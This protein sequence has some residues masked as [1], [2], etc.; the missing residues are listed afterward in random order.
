MQGVD[1]VLW[2]QTLQNQMQSM[3]AAAVAQQAANDQIRIRLETQI[4]I[5][6]GTIAVLQGTVSS[7]IA[8]H[9]RE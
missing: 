2:L 6:S 3:Q 7:I 1:V 8:V 9:S 5:N 4:A